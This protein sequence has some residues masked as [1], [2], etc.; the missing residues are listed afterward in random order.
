MTSVLRLPKSTSLSLTW[1]K[2]C[3]CYFS[4]G[5]FIPGPRGLLLN[6]QK[7][8][9]KSLTASSITFTVHWKSLQKRMFFSS[10]NF[11]RILKWCWLGTRES[12]TMTAPT[13]TLRLKKLMI[14]ENMVIPK[15]TVRIR[16]YR[17]GCLWM[18]MRFLSPSPSLTEMRM[19]NLRWNHWR[20]RFFLTL[21]WRNL[22]FVQMQDYHQLQTVFST[23]RRTGNLLQRNQSKSWKDISRITVLMKMDGTL[24]Q[25][26]QS[27]S[28]V[29]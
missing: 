24:S 11:T 2:S 8:F 1:I 12:F 17:W 22:L 3:L 25:I 10:L 27:I 6:F 16:L 13:I 29:N 9:L 21:E 23:T 7:S 5:L 26:K 4:L 20:K 15:K 14:S 18:Q 28:S 19:N